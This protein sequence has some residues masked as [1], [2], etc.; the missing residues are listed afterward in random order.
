MLNKKKSRFSNRRGFSS[1]SRLTT[2][3][4]RDILPQILSRIS[5]NFDQQPYLIIN[6]WPEIVGERVAKM[7]QAVS[8]SDGVLLVRVNNSS[9]YT[10]L[11]QYDKPKIVKKLRERFPQTLIKTVLFRLG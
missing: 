6:S 1:D 2:K 3:Q 10:L 4:I 8:F 5:T 9:L 7:T 11:H